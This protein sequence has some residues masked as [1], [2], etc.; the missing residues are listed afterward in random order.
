MR[1]AIDTA[2]KD[3]SFVIL[4]DDVS[5][6]FEFAQWSAEAHGWVRENGKPSEITPT[7]WQTMNLPEDGDEFS[8]QHE[9]IPPRKTEPTAPPASQQPRSF[10]FPAGQAARARAAE[11]T[12]QLANPDPVDIT[13]LRA[14][15]AQGK[16]ERGP[17]ARRWLAVASI[18]TVM[19]G[20]ALIG[21][22]ELAASSKT[23]ETVQAKEAAESANGELRVSLQKERD[24]AEALTGELLKARRDLETKLTL[25]S[26]AG[27]EAVQVK[28]A[29]ESAT[30]ELRQ[31]LQKAQQSLQKERDRAEALTSELTKARQAAET[32]VA[33]SSKAGDEAAQLKQ[34]KAAESATAEL[35]QS[36]QKERDR[37]EAL[38]GELVKAKRE[39]ET[40][41]A[42]SKKAGDEAAQG[43]QAAER[44]TA[45][46]RQSLQKEHD[47]AEA[48]NGELAKAKRESDIQLALSKK[49]GDEAAQGKQAA[50]RETT[51]LRR[52]L[53][54]ERERAELLTSELAKAKRDL[55]TQLAR[56]SKAGDE[57]AQLKQRKEAAES[58]MAELRGSLQQERNRAEAPAQVRKTTQPAS[59]APTPV[60]RA[61]NSQIAQPTQAAEA[62][63]PE[64]PA[65]AEAQAG[66][67]T[68]RLLA[69]ASAL[70]GQGN[71][72]AARIVLERA[73]ETGSA[74]ASFML[75]ET[76]D[77]LVLS[78]WKTYGTH[79]DVTKAR[80]LYAKALA[81]GIQEAKDRSV[82]LH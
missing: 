10:V 54:N 76:Y 23:G 16:S 6:S 14:E 37:A 12:R 46:L 45:E 26:K 31:S 62:V 17:R 51:D 72:G 3:G 8:V 60:E 74:Q 73:V 68:P 44:A 36:L 71:I 28:K 24:R 43:K 20:A 82:A 67:E 64:Q 79:G 70:I 42:L 29:A 33:L 22:Y 41:L 59:E 40:Q 55:E 61:S 49:A 69:R 27:D 9:F 13:Q 63:A 81:G 65:A 5:G 4:E 80:E 18:A 58:A 30:A 34:L 66:A 21:W 77:P 7:H 19:F 75:A 11:L 35:R 53:Q 2:P 15:A 32:K 50:E 1:R 57:A 56:S 39:S 52:S 48:L 25:S 47:R 38:S 78:T